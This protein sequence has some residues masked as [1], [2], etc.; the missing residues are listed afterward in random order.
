MTNEEYLKKLAKVDPAAARE[1]GADSKI[2]EAAAEE[3]SD[4]A[5]ELLKQAEKMTETLEEEDD[6]SAYVEESD[7]DFI[8][9]ERDHTE[10]LIREAKERLA[11]AEALNKEAKKA[12]RVEAKAE[13]AVDGR[14]RNGEKISGTKIY[15]GGFTEG[16]ADF[17]SPETEAGPAK[18]TSV[19]VAEQLANLNEQEN[20]KKTMQAATKF[21]ITKR[22]ALQLLAGSIIYAAGVNLFVSPAGTYSGGVM[23]ITQL[24]YTFAKGA[25]P[26]VAT[27]P[28]ISI[29][30]YLL[31][32][33]LFFLAYN[34]L[35]MN[36]FVRTVI[37]LTTESLFLSI[38]PVP[39]AMLVDTVSTSAILGGLCCGYGA[40]LIFLSRSSG[41]GMDVIGMV[42][43]KKYQSFSIGKI[44]MSVNAIIYLICALTQDVS[45]AL[46]SIIYAAVNSIVVDKVHAQNICSEITVYTKENPEL[47]L[48][49]ITK[50][51][52]RSAT[53]WDGTTAYGRD[54]NHVI[55]TVMSK[56]E[57]RRFEN[58]LRHFD[59]HAFA[60]KSHGVA[61]EG[62]FKK[63]L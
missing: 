56:Y 46:Y 47:L 29:V 52:G 12:S 21:H 4:F 3:E 60:V 61:V 16:L 42:M 51:M 8:N 5:N 23:G 2:L 53:Y 45:V 50:T 26:V 22:E 28:F 11:R 37:C 40:G 27:F 34:Q 48:D 41:G 9:K 13:K 44:S 7:D 17:T 15:A 35:G 20:P 25:F 49:F 19:S 62:N 36:F 10:V 33:P 24:L 32:V 38:I 63:K 58:F 59:P 18:K 1:A 14:R 6:L 43:T 55:Y 30:Y 57:V 54:R 31:N 39:N